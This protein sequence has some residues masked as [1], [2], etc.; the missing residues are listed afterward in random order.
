[1]SR[2]SSGC[3]VD[4]S[5]SGCPVTDRAADFDPF[6]GAYQVDPAEALRWARDQAPVFFAPKLGYWVVSRYD[7]VKAVFRDPILFSARN[8]LEKMAP[9]R[10][11][12]GEVLASYGYQ[13]NRTLV[14]EDEPAHMERRRVLMDHFLPENLAPKAEMIRRLTREKMDAFI[15]KGRADLVA[16][17]LYEVPL[18]VALHF[19]GV[20]EDEIATLRSFSVAHA[21]NTWGR[22]TPEQQL[23]VAH[24]VGKFW[25]YA[26][27][28]IEKMRAEP[29]G[30]GWM[31]H[32]IRMN[33]QM[34]DVVTDSY[35]HSMMMAIIVAAH[36]T[37]SLAS[38]N[39]VKTLLTHR[40][41]WDDICADPSLIPNAV[42]EC[43]RY[44]GSVVAWRR[45]AT[46][47][48]QIAGVA[49]PKGAKLLIVQASANHDERHFEDGDRFD[50]YRDNTADHLTFGY[51]AHQ[52]MGKNIGRMEMRIFLE[53]LT[54]R[55]PHLRLADQDFTYLPN[56][57][58]RGPDHLWVE[59]DPAQNPERSTPAPA[60]QQVDFPVGA[61]DRKAVSRPVRVAAVRHEADGV[62]GLTLEDA[63]GRPL[64]RWSP[65]AHVELIVDGYDR[66]YSLCGRPDARGYDL[67]ILRED[68]GRGGSTHIHA[69]VRAG[70]D[71]KL[72]GPHNLFRLD[73]GAP[74]HLLI[75]GGIGITPIVTMADRL[76]SLGRPY[77]IHYAGARR[78]GMALLDRLAADHGAAL[79]VHAQD[80]GARA[81]L[82]A[83]IAAL[84]AGGQVYA[85]GPDRMI[86]A[87]E[88]LTADL[89][90]GTLHVEHFSTDLGTLDPSK[91]H[92]FT[93]ELRDS[94][95]TLTVPADQTLLDTLAGA[96]IDVACDCREGLCGSC[97]VA[98]LEGGIDHRDRVLS[99][100]ER[101][102]GD[103][104]MSCCSRAAGGRLVLGL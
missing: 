15:D 91:E 90:E 10:P 94:V 28:I 5:A 103:R 31:H 43:L 35:V 57:S 65:G 87:L 46:A 53:E 29:E 18:N 83:L 69:V 63:R 2:M 16:E 44:A 74:F 98:V 86:A 3:P 81:D 104:M 67:A 11:E 52:C 79:T 45:E 38:V 13:L 39:M 7:D 34:P 96:G 89:P 84:P 22:P 19:L 101:A 17:M 70:M 8:A 49:I 68:Q 26:G 33:A 58:F 61:P 27:E 76:K 100:A 85:C 88:S 60:R 24:G 71:L 12:V 80:E 32:T 23:E 48:T 21:V 4:H 14:N 9:T 99:R 1:M 102:A 64:P 82:P 56:T 59:W 62:L 6:E 47:D 97:E 51:G 78:A 54:R 40:D 42:E 66:K 50:I 72:R 93:V 92:A 95:L 36:E 55:L 25:R 30:Q 41:A 77:A 75:A 37:T 73:E 20:P